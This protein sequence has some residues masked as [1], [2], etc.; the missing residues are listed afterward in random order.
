MKLKMLITGVSGLLGNNLAYY[1]KSHHEILGLY[2][3]NPIMIS[4]IQTEQCDLTLKENVSAI[5]THFVPDVIIHCTSLANIDQ[6]EKDPE[7]A[8]RLNIH[9]TKNIVE[10]LQGGNTRLVYISTDA[11]Y[12]GDK[13]EFSETDPTWPKNNYGKTK[14]EGE[15]EA[16]RHDPALVLRTNIFGWNIQNKQSLGEWI[17][18]ELQSGRKINGFIDA[19]F[20][21]IYTFELAR[22]IDIAIN[23]KLGGIYNCASAD[24]CSKYEFALK[25]ANWFDLDREAICPISIDNS[26]FET[27]RGKNLSLNVR[28]IQT[29]LNYKLPTIDQSIG[30]FYRDAQCQLSQNIKNSASMLFYISDIIPYGRQLV[31]QNDIEAVVQVLRFGC[32]TQGPKIDMFATSLSNYCSAQYALAVNSGTSA[33]HIACLAADLQPGDEVI[34]SP[35]TFVASANCAAYCGAI[36][37]FAD[38]DLRTY[39]IALEEI[40]K[41]ITP[42]TKAIIP[43]HFAGQSCE[44]EGLQSIVKEAEKRFGHKIYIIEDASHALG[45]Q[46]KKTQVG[47]CAYSDMAVLRFHPV[48]HIT[49]GEG[50][51]VLTN[52]AALYQKLRLFSSHGISKDSN[53]PQVNKHRWY[54]EQVELGHNYRIT[55]IQCAL[56]LS[57]LKKLDSFVSR[58]REVVNRYNEAFAQVDHLHTPFE[59]DN[60][61]SNFHLYVLLVDFKKIGIERNQLMTDLLSKGV[62]TQVHYIPVHT[63]PYYRKHYKTNW[64]DFPKAENYYQRCLSLPLFP[65]I[66]DE[67]VLKVI[68]SV[69]TGIQR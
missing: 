17:L 31:D 14:L 59:S 60:C 50:G 2:F 57:Q 67:E 55:D 65:A 46:Y 1:F 48:K 21:S 16:L 38:I 22:V 10:T 24:S 56:G 29:A 13:G 69:K 5:L 12:D 9:T 58:R 44:M 20:S 25:I 28:A 40:E 52:N 26:H 42:K 7:L 39:N 11:V 32:I 37:I 47:S 23:K 15:K 49:T 19:F 68:N 34:T 18:D 30:A 35:I 8:Q 64:G 41:K 6:C 27:T 63:Q 4:G 3:S 36:P 53:S 33:L 43:V 51:A 45:S 66:A 62:Q 61:N 54:Y